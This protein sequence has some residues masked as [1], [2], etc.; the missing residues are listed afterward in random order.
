MD[1]HININ[2]QNL[3]SKIQ[4]GH[5]EILGFGVSGRPLLPWLRAHGATSITVRD[6]RTYENMQEKGDVESIH[7]VGAAL[8][9]GEGYLQGLGD[10]EDTIIFRSPGIRPDLPEICHAV[11]RGAILTSEMELF[12]TLTPA[13]VYAITGSD[14][15]TTTTTLVATMLQKQM[16]RQGEGRVFL[17]GNLGNP[18]ITCLDTMTKD[19][20]AVVELSSFQLMTMP[21]EAHIHTAIITNI[22]PNHLNWHRDYN[23][24]IN[25]KRRVCQSKVLERVVLNAGNEHTYQMGNEDIPPHVQVVWF[26]A[27]DNQDL[28]PRD[29]EGMYM[30]LS[31]GRVC[32]W[33]KGG[34]VRPILSTS[35]ILLPG[36]HN[37]ENYMAAMGATTDV[38]HADIMV[39]VAERFAGVPH[40]LQLVREWNGVKFY[41][42]SID[43]SPSRTCAALSAL[44]ELRQR[45][46]NA[47]QP[48]DHLP[49]VICGG[50]DKHI[51]FDDLAT[52]LCR[53]ACRVVITGQAR[54]QIMDALQ[55]CPLF[56]AEKLPVVVIPDY[57]TAMKEACHMAKSGD[58]VL[59]SPACTSF[60]AFDDFAHRGNTFVSIVEALS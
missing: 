19:D 4:N 26:S 27:K 56:D 40:R 46:A 30:G 29:D 25:A 39:E 10:H 5:C 14:G 33:E 47:G 8:I 20:Y 59:L 42:S 23:E 54:E 18:L 32:L 11:E 12:L 31:D 7:S 1:H 21:P 53:M 13:R 34:E 50:Q 16:K 35:Q 43:S 17:G 6:K 51:P 52:G 22:T 9:C 45:Q 2:A 24:Y 36:L 3:L 55:T 38:V 28:P 48:I 49:I 58:V 57:V 37:V 15:K 41:N 44:G 60:D